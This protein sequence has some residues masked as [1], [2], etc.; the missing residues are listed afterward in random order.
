MI[1]YNN[2]INGHNIDLYNTT[3]VLKFL[4]EWLF[5]SINL[6]NASE[7]KS[8]LYLHKGKWDSNNNR[9]SR[10]VWHYRSNRSKRLKCTIL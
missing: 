3:E 9:N 8:C 4:K 5:E 7:G 1:W 10:G 2:N 6:P